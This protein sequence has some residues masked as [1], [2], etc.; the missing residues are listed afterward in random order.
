MVS[1]AW[2]GALPFTNREM[3]SSLNHRRYASEKTGLTGE[4]L[5][6]ETIQKGLR[7]RKQYNGVKI[8]ALPPAI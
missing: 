6:S 8:P 3:Q 5:S 4:T 1:Q 7:A 2:P